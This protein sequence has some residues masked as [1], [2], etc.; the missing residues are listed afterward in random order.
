MAGASPDSWMPFYVADYL[1]DT[2]H[3]ST[4]QHGAYCLLLFH[5]W[6]TGP[7][8]DDDRQLAAIARMSYRKW[9]N[10]AAILRAFFVPSPQGLTQARLEEER[11][12]A[13]DLYNKRSNAG[14]RGGQAKPK[15]TPSK[16]EAGLKQP[17]PQPQDSTNVLSKSVAKRAARVPDDW[18]PS[19]ENLTALE[20]QFPHVD[21]TAEC[22]A[23]R[24]WSLSSPNGKK[25]D[26]NAA[27]R[28][29]VRRKGSEGGQAKEESP[30]MRSLRALRDA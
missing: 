2:G 14:R 5:S 3:L 10:N 13:V 27:F 25:I 16:T 24:D 26:H 28:G 9:N 21:L 12:K 22:D 15:Q 19:P 8:P 1:G 29:W 20:T 4:E 23:Y 30:T 6:R 17:Q 11:T 7:L 18:M